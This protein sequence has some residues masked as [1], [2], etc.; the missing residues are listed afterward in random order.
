LTRIL[1][2]NWQNKGVMVGEASMAV[3][4]GREV[5]MRSIPKDS[6]ILALEREYWEAMITKEPA[7][8]TRLTADRSIVV[9]AQGVGVVSK[10]EIGS[11]V[12]S[13]KWK[14]RKFEF[15]DVKFNAMDEDTAIIAYAVKEDLEVDGKP[16]TL[17]ANDS[18][19]W[20]RRKGSWE[21]V[22]H[23]E[24]VKGDPFGRDRVH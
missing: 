22:L 14:L 19:V 3:A 10:Q 15:S 5:S 20:S 17:E 9:G 23:T 24:A 13:D 11:M 21:C 4:S 7:V 6:E 8:A 2:D 12:K 1:S 18:S 16:L